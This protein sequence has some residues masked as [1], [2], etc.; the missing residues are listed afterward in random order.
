MTAELIL[1]AFIIL[2][3]LILTDNFNLLT[4]LGSIIILILVYGLFNKKSETLIAEP[5]VE[6]A[7]V[8][9]YGISRY[10]NI[11]L[12]TDIDM[13]TQEVPVVGENNE[14]DNAD[15]IDQ[16]ITRGTSMIHNG[17]ENFS[18]INNH[19]NFEMKQKYNIGLSGM[20]DADEMLARKQSQRAAL[21]RDAIT[22]A[23]RHTKRSYDR[24]FAEE[25]DENEKRVWWSSEAQDVETDWNSY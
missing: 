8:N 22:G 17:N 7:N 15:T 23:V 18:V 6:N 2:I 20:Q 4:V 12:P 3:L 1:F 16:V 11:S 10:S 5:E 21:N 14:F 19:N 25:L 13:T 24:T 9:S